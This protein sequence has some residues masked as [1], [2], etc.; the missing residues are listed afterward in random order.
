MN[1]TY[2]GHLYTHQIETVSSCFLC[3][4]F[5]SK[6]WKLSESLIFHVALCVYHNLRNLT[7]LR[8]TVTLFDRNERHAQTIAFQELGNE[9]LLIVMRQ[10][11]LNTTGISRYSVK[12]YLNDDIVHMCYRLE[13]FKLNSRRW[14]HIYES[15]NRSCHASASE[16]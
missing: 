11:N 3:Q 15:E 8:S 14:G 7:T 4:S 6:S 13:R 9:R 2:D 10:F 1:K 5:L 12:I 16:I